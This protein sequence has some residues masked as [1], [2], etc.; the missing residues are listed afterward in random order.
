MANHEQ[1]DEIPEDTSDQAQSPLSSQG[2]ARRRMAGLGASGVLMTLASNN[3]MAALVCK[4]P[5][6]ALSGNLTSQRPG[7]S[8]SCQ[9]RSPG[10]WKNH[11]GSWPSDVAMTDNFSKYFPCQEPLASVT[12]LGIL[13][14]QK[15]DHHN[16][17][18]HLMATYLNVA[19]GRIGFLSRDTVVGMW[20]EYYNTRQYVPAE[21]ATPW[22]AS[23]LVD[24]LASTMG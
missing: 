13:R 5:S 7:G 15:A 14:K 17:G 18:M 24:Y 19:T 21:G 9:G 6:N 11:P 2:A 23:Q 22:S 12:C 8:V 4:S 10:Y 3:A 1:Q 16:V 20:T